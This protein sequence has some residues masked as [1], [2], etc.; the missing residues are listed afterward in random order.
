VRHLWYR[1]DKQMATWS[2]WF[3]SE[4]K[5]KKAAAARK[6]KKPA[7]IRKAAARNETRDRDS[8]VQ[9]TVVV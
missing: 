1:F 9:C 7:N 4:D 8:P 2:T 6:F 5:A 3:Y